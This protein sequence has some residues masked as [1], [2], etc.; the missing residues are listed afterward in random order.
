MTGLQPGTNYHFKVQSYDENRDYLAADSYSSVFGF[1]TDVAPGVA[2]VVISDVNLTSAIISWKTTTIATSKIYYGQTSTYGQELTDNSGSGVS[3][4]TIK[5]TN[6]F[7]SSTYHFKIIGTDTD[8]NNLVSDDYSFNTLMLPRIS[9]VTFEQQHNT[10]TSTIKVSWQSNVA[11]T[12]TILS[13]EGDSSVAKE[14][15]LST[16]TTDHSILVS[17]LKDDTLYRIIAEG[18]DIFGNLAVSD[19]NRVTTAYD[20]RPP[21][22]SNIVTESTTSGYG[23]DTT[24][25]III[26]WDTDEPATSQVEYAEGITGDSFSMSTAKDSSLTTSHVVVLRDLKPSSSY[27]FRVVSSDIAGN[28]TQSESGSALTGLIQSSIL[29]TVLKS[30]QG[31]FGWM[32]K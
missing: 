13:Y 26:Y 10:A 4:H 6:L 2:E 28:K 31:A 12:S 11:T 30:L 5:L 1:T 14:T 25:Q 20:T 32:F 22:L 16:L 24:A 19:V 21:D 27:Y 29:D 8:G 7:H 3:N 15:S 9:N 17:N 18:R 23:A